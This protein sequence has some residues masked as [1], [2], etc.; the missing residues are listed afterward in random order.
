M[1][2]V[3]GGGALTCGQ[4][5]SGDER[6]SGVLSC[7]ALG[8][9]PKRRRSRRTPQK[10]PAQ[11]RTCAR[12]G[13]EDGGGGQG[14]GG[15]LPVAGMD[16][17]VSGARGESRTSK[18]CG[19]TQDGENSASMIRDG[20]P[21]GRSVTCQRDSLSSTC[22]TT[23]PVVAG[24]VTGW[25]KMRRPPPVWATGMHWPSIRSSMRTLAE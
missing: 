5:A 11:V 12:G 19:A 3:A 23:T 25:S 2:C 18:P 4:A 13:A 22:M 16:S 15:G 17:C 20:C 10:R 24:N 7:K 1:E 8:A 21:L 14:R 6:L 9:K